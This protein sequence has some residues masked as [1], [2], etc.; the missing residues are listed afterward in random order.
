MNFAIRSL[1][2]CYHFFIQIRNYL[3]NHGLFRVTDILIPVVSVGNISFG[4]TGKTPMVIWIARQI[5]KA[6]FTVVILSRGYKRRSC[7]TRIVSDTAK[8]RLSARVLGAGDEP[9]L[10]AHKL[11]GVPVIVSKNRV[12]G[13]SKAKKLFKPNVI[14]LDDGFQHRKLERKVDIVLLDSPE[15]LHNNVCLREPL[16][17]L[18]R[19]DVVVFTKYDLYENAADIQ[20]EMVKTLSCP[21]FRAQY[22]PE[23]I[24]NDE[25]KYPATI[26]NKKTVWLVAGIAKPEYFKHKI[27]Q[28]GAHISRE[29]IYKDHARYSRWRMR[30]M[31]RKFRDSS[32]DYLITTEKDWHKLKR[33][34][35]TDIPCYY[36]DIDV[37]IHRASLFL[38]LIFDAAYLYKTEDIIE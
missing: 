4:G 27:K 19:A 11:P 8:I 23:F 7:F 31:I 22:K 1:Q 15:S 29:F 9:Y 35:P 18:R 17:N 6:G 13:A 26:L 36:L 21:V 5:Q 16:K 33:W 3:Y 28:V 37:D 2:T 25:Q 32:A 20:K 38:K 14:L 10:I 30:R 12:R 34:I 24:R